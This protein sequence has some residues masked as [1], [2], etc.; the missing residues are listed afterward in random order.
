MR[1]APAPGTVLGL[2]GDSLTLDTGSAQRVMV[3]S[4]AAGFVGNAREAEANDDMALVAF[5]GQVPV[6]VRKARNA[7]LRDAL[8]HAGYEAPKEDS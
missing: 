5:M 4:S 7:A 1:A 8:A 6:Q 2:S 3:V